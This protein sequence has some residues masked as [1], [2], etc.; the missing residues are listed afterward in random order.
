M[1]IL[2][3]GATGVLGA[4][5]ARELAPHAELTALVRRRRLPLDGVRQLRGDL[6]QTAMGM[7]AQDYDEVVSGTDVVV[8]CG[9]MTAFGNKPDVPR[10]VNVEGTNRILELTARAGARLVHVSTAFVARASEFEQPATTG[11]RTPA[12]YV[13]SKV[14]AEQLVFGSGLDPVVV[15][16]SVLMGDSTSGHI[17]AF[18]GWHT[19]CGATIA[20]QTPFLPAGPDTLVDS[21]PVDFAARAI[22]SIALAGAQPGEWWLTAGEDAFTLGESLQLCLREA[23]ERGLSPDRPRL[24]PREMVERLVLPAFGQGV[25]EQLQ[26]QLLEGL[27]LMRM[28]GSDRRFPS[29]WPAEHGAPAPTREQLAVAFEASL[30]YLCDESGLQRLEAA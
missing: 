21:V 6:T 13:R 25:S 15:R 20:G 26:R 7:A 19:M 27:E 24:L 1:R 30:R 17:E 29:R 8:H 4:V 5:V 14:E 3:T 28:F 2:L 18:Q 11:L 23:S 10:R 22:A 16:P 12:S 9:A